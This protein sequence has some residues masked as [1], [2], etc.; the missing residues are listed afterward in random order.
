M[1]HRQ[2]V[3]TIPKRLRAYCLY[4]RRLLG[5]IARVAARTV[6]AAIRTLTG[7]RELTVGIAPDSGGKCD[8]PAIVSRVLEHVDDGYEICDGITPDRSRGHTAVACVKGAVGS[9]TV[10]TQEGLA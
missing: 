1:P 8:A 2:G 7:E 4:R 5:E 9:S 6:T 3:L 10:A